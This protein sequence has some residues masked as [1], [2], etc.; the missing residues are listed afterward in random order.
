MA[1]RYNKMAVAVWDHVTIDP[2]EIEF[3]AGDNIEV[4][5]MT[6]KN[7]W[8]GRVPASTH[9][10]WFPAAFVKVNTQKRGE[11]GVFLTVIV[12]VAIL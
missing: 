8:R 5:D 3:D 6:D 10:G 4:L 2:D 1:T 7:W 11:N 9:S 12:F